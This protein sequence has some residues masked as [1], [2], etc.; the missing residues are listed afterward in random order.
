LSLAAAGVAATIIVLVL[1]HDRS[2]EHAPAVTTAVD[3][4]NRRSTSS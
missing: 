4:G 2:L 1:P 3:P